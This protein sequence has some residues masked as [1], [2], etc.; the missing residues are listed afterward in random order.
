MKRRIWGPT[1]VTGQETLRNPRYRYFKTPHH[2][3]RTALIFLF[4]G[5]IFSLLSACSRSGSPGPN[6][7]SMWDSRRSVPHSCWPKTW[8]LGP[9][10]AA[11]CKAQVA[12][13]QLKSHFVKWW[14]PEPFS[15]AK[16]TSNVSEAMTQGFLNYVR[17]LSG[18]FLGYFF[19]KNYDYTVT[20]SIFV[21]QIPHTPSTS[22]Q[23]IQL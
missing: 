22:G 1:N 4:G 3:S 18:A 13:R 15:L 11:I 7:Y 23:I 19:A 14:L 16:T 10:T 9:I 5:Q 6:S 17:L 21:A 12:H 8:R 20:L 2:R